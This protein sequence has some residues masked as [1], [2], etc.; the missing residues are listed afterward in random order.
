MIASPCV[1]QQPGWSGRLPGGSE[2]PQ[3]N[4]RIQG[5]T[6]AGVEVDRAVLPHDIETARAVAGDIG[7]PLIPLGGALI[8]R[9]IRADG[10]ART[11]EDAVEDVV[12]IV[13]PRAPRDCET[14]AGQCRYRHIAG[15]DASRRVLVGDGLGFRHGAVGVEDRIFE[16]AETA[17]VE[18]TPDG[19]KAPV[20][21][22]GD[23]RRILP[24]VDVGIQSE[25]RVR[26]CRGRHLRVSKGVLR[27]NSFD[28]ETI[29]LTH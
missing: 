29:D 16:G 8:A 20:G 21:Q 5:H 15:L 12:L 2:V 9:Q 13:Q 18:V 17:S 27:E 1:A 19:D 4:A 28:P 11:V 25:R 22:A 26:Q 10:G 24:A 6:R 7:T 14:A 23:R 3:L